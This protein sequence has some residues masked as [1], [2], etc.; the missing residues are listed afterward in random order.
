MPI[1][2][3]AGKWKWGNIERDTR[4]DLRRTVYGI[5]QKNG[6]KGDFGDYWLTGKIKESKKPPKSSQD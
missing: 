6:S 4:D 2:T 1:R 5:W 3:K